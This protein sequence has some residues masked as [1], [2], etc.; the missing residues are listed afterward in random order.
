[1]RTFDI[2]LAVALIAQIVIWRQGPAE[3]LDAVRLEKPDLVFSDVEVIEIRK[4][5][6]RITLKKD[7]TSWVLP[8]YGNYPLRPR[9]AEGLLARLAGFF[10]GPVIGESAEDARAYRVDDMNPYLKVKLRTARDDVRTINL[11]PAPADS[12]YVRVDGDPR[13]FRLEPPLSRQVD[14]SPRLWIDPVLYS[15][16]KFPSRISFSMGGQDYV[17]GYDGKDFRC[18]DQVLD[19]EKVVDFV[20]RMHE[21][22]I[23]EPIGTVDP[24]TANN[25]SPMTLFFDVPERPI[26]LHLWH[27]VHPNTGVRGFRVRVNDDPREV[28]VLEHRLSDVFRMGLVRFMPDSML[29]GDGPVVV[30]HKPR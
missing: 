23:D 24:F 28:F 7:G 19:K 26:R 17:I 12:D 15:F 16:E 22:P 30:P 8:A 20:S 13:V 10:P 29:S 4:D 25:F 27:H 11:S 18:L 6:N 1:M 5:D 2:V 14:P 21:L 3:A 9:A